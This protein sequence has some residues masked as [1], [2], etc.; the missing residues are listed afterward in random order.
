MANI[1]YFVAITSLDSASLSAASR[2]I[3]AGD[4]PNLDT[5]AEDRVI[6]TGGV[7][8]FAHEKRSPREQSQRG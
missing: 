2:N 5:V 4:R 3:L 6:V 8:T 7:A 1:D